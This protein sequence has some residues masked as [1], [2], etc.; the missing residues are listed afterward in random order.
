M[1]RLEK[2]GDD[3][4]KRV[5][6]LLVVAEVVWRLGAGLRAPHIDAERVTKVSGD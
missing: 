1:A 4:E 2:K 3:A 5:L 6:L